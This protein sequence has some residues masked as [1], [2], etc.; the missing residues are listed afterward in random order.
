M[1]QRKLREVIGLQRISPPRPVPELG[2][3]RRALREN[4]IRMQKIDEMEDV[5]VES[6]HGPKHPH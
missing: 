3:M 2:I 1:A 5:Q 6:G 4:E